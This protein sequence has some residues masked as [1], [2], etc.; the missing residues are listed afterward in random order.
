MDFFMFAGLGAALHTLSNQ[1]IYVHGTLCHP[2]RLIVETAK[3]EPKHFRDVKILRSHPEIGYT[4]IECQAGMIESTFDALK[5]TKCPVWLDVAHTATYTPND[6]RW[7]DQW[8][9]RSIKADQAWDLSFGSAVKVAVIDTGVEYTHEDLAANMWINP[10]EIAGNGI[11]DDNNG[12]IDD[13]RGYDFVNNDGDPMD[14]QGHG[15]ACAGLVG[16]V[17]D[18]LKGVT[19]VAPRA[20]IM[21]IKAGNSSGYFYASADIGSFIYGANMG[22][23]VFSMS[24]FGDQITQPEHVALTYAYNHNV[25]PIAAAGNDATVYS[26]YPGAYEETL[27]V[28]AL[29]TD[30]VSK[31]GFSDFGSWVDVASPGVSLTTTAIGNSYTNGFAGTSGACPQVAGLATLVIGA[32]PLLTNDQARAIIE[33]TC[34][35]V[36]QSPFGE[37]ANYGRVDCRAAVQ[38]AQTM[39]WSGKSALVR[40]I[41]PYGDIKAPIKP[42][43]VGRIYGRGFQAPHVVQVLEGTKPALIKAQKRDYVDYVL[44][45][46]QQPVT[47]KVDGSTVTTIPA[48]DVAR[49]SFSLIEGASPGASVNGGFRETLNWDNQGMSVTM[50]GDNT[51]QLQ[52]IFRRVD[53]S[54]PL[55]LH[56]VRRYSGA[57]GGQ[58]AVLLYNWST[59]SYPYGSFTNFWTDNVTA[60]SS[61]TSLDVNIP[62]PAN[63]VDGENTMYFLM[64]VSGV[65]GGNP[66]LFLDQA[67]V[68]QK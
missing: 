3:F 56:I 68:Y 23:R 65:T 60:L 8:H 62:N 9:T 19:G 2:Q 31:A 39:T 57:T 5:A 49:L 53:T 27:S 38:A 7:P 32:N 15:T 54:K 67:E 52:G 11:D 13:V 28:A 33:D 61:A 58:E 51:I 10:G 36:F 18:N 12:Y 50:R 26:F 1:P 4:I 6:P 43:H 59:A 14:D 22:A 64:Y 41:S 16:G 45:G 48:P 46:T 20:K 34:I 37:F 66:V 55:R 25:L 29:S 30:G 40:W 47:V 35:P 44:G 17:Q 63:Y 42:G 21:A 24:F